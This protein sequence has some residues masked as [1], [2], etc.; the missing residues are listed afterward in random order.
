[1]GKTIMSEEKSVYNAIYGDGSFARV[2]IGEILNKGGAAGKIFLVENQPSIVAKIFHNTNRSSTNREKLQAMLLNPPSFSPAMKDGKEYLMENGHNYVQIAW[3]QALLENEEGFCVGYL[4]PLVDM[5]HAASLDHFMQKAIRQ[6]LKLSEK[7]E[8][9]LQVAYNLCTMV[10]ALHAKGHYIV[11]LKP[12]NVYAYKETMLVAM[13][14][15]D[16]FSIRGEKNRY[17]AEYVSE[18]YIY[19]EGM[20]QSC[21]QMGEEQDK[22][23]LSVI[24]FKLMN[25][26]IHPFSGIPRKSDAINLTIQERIADNHY[27]Y[28]SWADLYQAPHPYSVHDYFAKNTL[29]LFDRAFVKGLK[30]PSAE[31]W[32]QH[33]RGLLQNLRQCKKN[34]NHVYFSS[35]GCGLCAADEKFKSNLSEI[36][37]QLQTPKMVRGVEIEK[38]S[39]EKFE[40]DKEKKRKKIIKA[41]HITLVVVLMYL[42]FFGFFYRMLMPI[43]PQLQQIGMGLQVIFI[44]F[45]MMLIHGV[46]KEFKAKIPL[47]RYEMLPLMLQLFALIC[48]VISLISVNQLPAEFFQLMK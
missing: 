28:G 7:Y 27:A 1:M 47:F 9:R 34:S 32:E 41:N 8:H 17:P 23:A 42:L 4:M 39:P 24:L 10:A 31:E 44:I 5:S 20:K 22:F 46:I 43:A 36:Q 26:G 16:G 6:K 45:I 48:M 25:N 15:C 30:R 12:S 11:D 33:I 37:R 3:P 2:T 40:K 14:D 29:E 21:D 35:R 19:P 18:E 13:L 38:I